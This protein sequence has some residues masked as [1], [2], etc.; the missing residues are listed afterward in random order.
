M[1]N[2]RRLRRFQFVTQIYFMIF[3][4]SK[5]KVK[6]NNNMASS[7]ADLR[8]KFQDA[9]NQ[10]SNAPW[11]TT[12]PA[13]YRGINTAVP[14]P[15]QSTFSSNPFLHNENVIP[16]PAFPAPPV[17]PQHFQQQ[18]QQNLP[19]QINHQTNPSSQTAGGNDGD[20]SSNS[21]NSRIYMYLVA[22][23]ILLV[24]IGLAYWGYKKWCDSSKK[25][26]VNKGPTDSAGGRL[27]FQRGLKQ[28]PS[29][30]DERENRMFGMGNNT[31]PRPQMNTEEE[32]DPNFT[33]LSAAAA[34]VGMDAPPTQ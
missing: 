9:I 4:L 29:I 5:L 22:F 25:A 20:S 11:V 31:Q 18:L 21:G 7:T 19:Q 27:P 28:T 23:V 34:A 17:Q 13:L 15:Q 33:S 26:L 1:W 16:P 32:K 2:E 14:P 8:S 30:S 3:L 10:G 6:E 12:P 24:L